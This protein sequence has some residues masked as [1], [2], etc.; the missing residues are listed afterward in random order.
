M[1][2]V[3]SKDGNTFGEPKIVDT[4]KDFLEGIS[5]FK[6]TASELAGGEEIIAVA[7]GVRALD[8]AKEKL[9]NQPHFPMWVDEPFKQELQNAIGAA[10]YLEND[11]AMVGLGEAVFGSGKEYRIVAYITISTGVGGVRIVDRKID[12]SSQ[13]FEPGNQIINFDNTTKYLEACISGSALEKRLGKKAYEITDPAVWEKEAELLAYGLNNVSVFWSP[14]VI[15][16]G[17]SM[18]LGDPAIPLDRVE[19]HL[20]NVL[21]ILPEPPKLKKAAL[22]DIGGLYGALAF[23]KQKI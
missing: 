16:L 11:A 6:K 9:R 13:G 19:Y 20:K 12:P 5:L 23:L 8:S 17:G 18:I 22:G 7:G 10:V 21:K 2:F 4:P 15:V 14:D 1:R 3:V